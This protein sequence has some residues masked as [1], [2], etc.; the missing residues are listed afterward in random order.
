MAALDHD[1]VD[2]SLREW[3]LEHPDERVFVGVLLRLDEEPPPA[4][5]LLQSE[6]DAIDLHNQESALRGRAKKGL[7]IDP[8]ELGR[9]QGRRQDLLALAAEE[10]KQAREEYRR[11]RLE[12][13]QRLHEAVLPLLR[14]I[15]G[16]EIYEWDLRQPRR[17][18]GMTITLAHLSQLVRIESVVRVTKSCDLRTSLDVS[19]RAIRADV[20]HADGIV[21]DGMLH[22]LCGAARM[23]TRDV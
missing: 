2:P 7:A 4:P 6:I 5:G 21:G 3:F 1:K 23:A 13:Y 16:L 11:R 20:A 18:I 15:E 22:R 14:E 17:S 8:A 10:K 19:H 9:V 12:V